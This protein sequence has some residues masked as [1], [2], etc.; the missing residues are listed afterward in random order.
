MPQGGGVGG[1]I[2]YEEQGEGEPLL[3]IPCLA[4]DR[5]CWAFQ[6]PAYAEHF[7]CIVVD[8]PGAGDSPTP[9]GTPS[10]A[11]F[12][13]E[14][15]LLLDDLGLEAAHVAGV[16]LGAAV[17]MQLAGRH[18]DRVLTLGLHSAWTRTDAFMRACMESWRALARALPTMADFVACGVFPWAFTPEMY[19][20]RPE[21]IREFTEIVRARDALSVG[22]F[23]AQSQAVIDHD[24][25]AV[26]ER[27]AAPTLV[28]Y[29]AR[30][31]LTSTRFAPALVD[32]I[33]DA[34]LTVF[35]HLSHAGFNEDPDTFTAATLAFM[36]GGGAEA[37]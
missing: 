29:G 13:D 25:T 21:V 8:L 12:A 26:L 35:D 15:A 6:V 22:G 23:I 37:P 2:G 19:A 27:I 11:R 9:S 7:R 28:T 32:G 10:T 34:R 18:P 3:L 20:R 14:L 16:S 33:A 4:A 17:G 36:R 24:A 5:T 31:V 30:D 1:T